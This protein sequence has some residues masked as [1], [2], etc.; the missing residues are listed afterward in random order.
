MQCFKERLVKKMLH[1]LMSLKNAVFLTAAIYTG[2]MFIKE[3]D[4]LWLVTSFMWSM[5][6]L[7]NYNMYNE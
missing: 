7:V 5:A 6:A 3:G 1:I 2:G 4:L